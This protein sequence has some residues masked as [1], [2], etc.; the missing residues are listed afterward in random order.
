MNRIGKSLLVGGAATVLLTATLAYFFFLPANAF[1]NIPKGIT[2]T[3][4]N[5]AILIARTEPVPNEEER[6]SLVWMQLASGAFERGN[7]ST[8]AE[9]YSRIPN[10]Y[11]S[12]FRARAREGEVRFRLQQAR[13]AESCLTRAIAFGSSKETT[14]LPEWYGAR[15]WLRN[16]L[17][18]EVRL[19]ERHALLAEIHT[20]GQPSLF[21]S[22]AWC[23]PSQLRWNREETIGKLEAFWEQDP[24]DPN[25]NL[26][27]VRFRISE[28]RT[29]DA[30]KILS[31]TRWDSIDMRRVAAAKLMLWEA[32]GNWAQIQEFMA[33]LPP[34]SHSD[35]W[36][37]LE[38]RGR[39]CIHFEKLDDAM[40]SYETLLASDPCNSSACL[41]T[42][43]I[44][45]RRGQKERGKI[46]LSRSEVLARI[47][48]RLGNVLYTKDPEALVAIAE[49]CLE[50]GLT[51]QAYWMAHHAAISRPTHLRAR[52]IINQW[53]SSNDNHV[54]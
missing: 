36:G 42:S 50:V 21:D 31:A 14:A 47:Q 26:A 9:C 43:N 40:A 25:L 6:D 45:R 3:E 2:S 10:L 23:F 4:L 11:T 53:G 15:D 32:N 13:L 7:Y 46:L 54:Q 28:G 1:K 24:S 17:E 12:G 37:L 22:I 49:L 41:A 5:D 27:L 38:M 44:C 33:S 29:D 16:L 48:N 30:A 20:H 52:E 39:T 8:A 51:K 35:P 19:E 34:V 18:I